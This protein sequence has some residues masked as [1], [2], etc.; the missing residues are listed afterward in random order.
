MI[1]MLQELV[2][3]LALVGTAAVVYA[4]AAARVIRQYERG[5]VLRFGRLMGSVRGPGF[6]LIVPG[7]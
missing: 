7:V 6:T 5:V 4:A 1:M 3:A 2:T